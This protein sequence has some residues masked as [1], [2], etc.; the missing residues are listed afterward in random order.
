MNGMRGMRKDQVRTYMLLDVY[1]NRSTILNR[2]EDIFQI[3]ITH[4]ES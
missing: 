2:D 4:I 1:F 3:S